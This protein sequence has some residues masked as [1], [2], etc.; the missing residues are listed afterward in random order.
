[1]FE[2][3][4]IAHQKLLL[5]GKTLSDENKLLKDANIKENSKLTLVIKKPD[6]LKDVIQRNFKKS[7]P[8]DSAELLSKAFFTDFEKKI[9]QVSEDDKC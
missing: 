3:F 1:M 4:P 6:S 9:S 8:E 7:Y 2:G 5:I